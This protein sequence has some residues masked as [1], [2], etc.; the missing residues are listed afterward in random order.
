MPKKQ[1]PRAAQVAILQVAREP[2]STKRRKSTLADSDAGEERTSDNEI[3]RPYINSFKILQSHYT[4]LQMGNA[5]DE[6]Q[7]A[8]IEQA[9]DSDQFPY[10]LPCCSQEG[11]TSEGTP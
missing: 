11:V 10:Y 3:V 4:I 1:K 5:S 8:I 7:P 2:L 6:E 9:D